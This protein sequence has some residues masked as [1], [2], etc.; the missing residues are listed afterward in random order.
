M[1]ANIGLVMGGSWHDFER[2]SEHIA[3]W[4]GDDARRVQLLPPN[5]LSRLDEL[6]CAAAILY[7]CLDDH[8]PLRHDAT[9]LLA[10]R[11]WVQRG[12]GLVALHATAVAAKEHP[13]LA[14]LLGG[15]FESHPPKQRFLVSP[16]RADC[17]LARGLKAFEIED[18]RYELTLRPDVSVELTTD[19]DGRVLPLAWT[20]SEGLGRVAYVSLGH[21]ESAWREP[22]YSTLVVRALRW[23]TSSAAPL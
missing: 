18:E 11:S 13:E 5:G 14:A 22:A 7:T 16:A 3:T 19:V 23:A 4:L 17:A 6:Q 12:G 9:N 1:T 21:D 2:F 15:H 20:R 8:T 10:L